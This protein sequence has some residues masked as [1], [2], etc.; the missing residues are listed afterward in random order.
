[1]STDT[2]PIDSPF[3][4]EADRALQHLLRRWEQARRMGTPQTLEEFCEGS[5]PSSDSHESP[6]HQSGAKSAPSDS[7][8]SSGGADSLEHRAAPT[9]IGSYFTLKRIGR[10]GTCDVYLGRH[11]EIDRHVALKVFR[12]RT[13]S[14]H[15]LDRFRSEV[16]HLVQLSHPG[17]VQVFDA[18]VLRE[19]GKVRPWF[20]MELVAGTELDTY[21]RSLLHESGRS[22]RR[23]AVMLDICA[24]VSHAHH[25]GIVHCDLKFRN[26]LV[27]ESGRIKV[28]DFGIARMRE[29]SGTS[30]MEHRPAAGT[31]PYMA[32]ERFAN[33]DT[34]QDVRSDVYSLGIV[35]Y[36]MYTGRFP[37][38]VTSRNPSRWAAAI[39]ATA[40]PAPRQ[41][42]A[43]IDRDLEAVILKAIAKDRG[44][45][46]QSVEHFAEDI[47]RYRD[48]WP[49]SA[50]PLK[51][52]G[53]LGHWARRNRAL[54]TLLLFAVTSLMVACGVAIFFAGRAT[55]H[56]A[57]LERAT[58][59]AEQAR[60]RAVRHSRELEIARNDLRDHVANLK[61]SAANT[62]LWLASTNAE[63]SPHI[64][65]S[66]LE[67]STLL[68]KNEHGFVWQLLEKRTRTTL[69]LVDAHH[70]A[71]HDV[72]IS[73]SGNVLL[74]VGAD[75]TLRTWKL[76]NLTPIFAFRAKI[77]PRSMVAV[78][79]SGN[80]VV[81]INQIGSAV[82]IEMD[83]Q[84]HRY[85]LQ[86]PR[87]QA[88]TAA[89]CPRTGRIAVGDEHGMVRIWEPE[90]LTVIKRWQMADNKIVGVGFAQDGRVAAVTK[91]GSLHVRHLGANAQDAERDS[92]PQQLPL[93]KIDR[94]AFDPSLRYVIA[95]RRP[96]R[97][98]IWDRVTSQQVANELRTTAATEKI[99]DVDLGA[100]PGPTAILADRFTVS[101]LSPNE[102]RIVSR[103]DGTALSSVTTNSTGSIIITG[104]EAGRIQVALAQPNRVQHDARFGDAPV[105]ILAFDRVRQ[106]VYG[107]CPSP[108]TI[109]VCDYQG[110]ILREIRLTP[111]E[112]LIDLIVDRERLQAVLQAPDGSV[113]VRDPQT[114]KV[115]SNALPMARRLRVGN[116]I[117]TGGG[118]RLLGVTRAGSVFAWDRATN[119][120]SEHESKSRGGSTLA[121]DR[122]GRYLVHSHAAPWIDLRDAGDLRVLGS[123]K[124]LSRQRALACS[125]THDLVACGGRNG[126]VEVRQLP[127]LELMR[128]LHYHTS[129]ISGIAF[130]PRERLMATASREGTV[131]AWDTTL[132]EPRCRFRVHGA[133]LVSLA[134]SPDG[135]CLVAGDEAGRMTLWHAG[136]A[137]SK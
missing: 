25:T 28:I 86:T 108:P 49:V 112:R 97:T 119:R 122:T 106:V 15:R 41:C 88:S 9:S 71:V 51:S 43:K 130:S 69:G 116:M 19:G 80:R 45:R 33:P 75:R 29:S 32:P 89:I 125:P 129:A 87:V 94:V 64:A 118:L 127:S 137:P 44:E 58:T 22:D 5:C 63:T 6:S 7:P 81:L 73:G 99:V 35:L 1:M 55:L 68:P 54:A 96:R 30:G 95:F 40:P 57:R 37:Y 52:L 16:A 98:V 114:L 60:E 34:A 62:A 121:I 42:G 101:T 124:T 2:W 48:G 84:H 65:R 123:A 104:D 83:R 113:R 36:R 27:G 17:I 11:H 135:T 24:A 134:F 120:L 8:A 23:L 59:A 126:V 4:D 26:I 77:D 12:A 47:R 100:L 109:C 102:R 136:S 128:E 20:A 103:T 70:G 46:Y 14:D 72:I 132:W 78:D 91:D 93:K 117:A 13:W 21:T 61:R 79:H 38:D 3:D 10:G 131:I 18:G 53:Q 92:Q 111:E 56:A 31:P 50:R 67:D 76:P 66:F 82:Y 85:L 39:E 107:A 110:R 133:H 90:Q 74:S 105:S 115:V